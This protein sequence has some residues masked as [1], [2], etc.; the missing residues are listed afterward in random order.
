MFKT[1]SPDNNLNSD[2]QKRRIAL[3]LHTGYGER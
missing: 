1:I 2:V 3:L